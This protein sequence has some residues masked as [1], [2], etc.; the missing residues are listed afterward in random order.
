[1]YQLREER[2]KGIIKIRKE[3][4]SE[5]RFIQIAKIIKI[6]KEREEAEKNP[7]KQYDYR[8][9]IDSIFG[10]KMIIFSKRIIQI[11]FTNDAEWRKKGEAI[12]TENNKL[13]KVLEEIYNS[14]PMRKKDG[15]GN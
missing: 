11:C 13:I 2:I 7:T 3:G 6:L 15:L 10:I 1:M 14:A 12:I 5:T 4:I 9:L 8:I